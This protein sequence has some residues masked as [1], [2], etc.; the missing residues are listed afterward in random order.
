VQQAGSGRLAGKQHMWTSPK[1][2]LSAR[3]PHSAAD[4]A[5]CDIVY[6]DALRFRIWAPSFPHKEDK[7]RRRHLISNPFNSSL[8]ETSLPHSPDRMLMQ[9]QQ[10][11]A[12]CASLRML[13]GKTRHAQG[14]KDAR[15]SPR[16]YKTFDRRCVAT[17]MNG[18]ACKHRLAPTQMVWMMCVIRA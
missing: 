13:A 3:L 2:L 8:L 5:L 7:L 14:A 11:W 12:T 15:R 18:W 10:Q 16:L 4:S 9:S 17:L 1:G 6:C